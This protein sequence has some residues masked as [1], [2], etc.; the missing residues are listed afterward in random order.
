MGGNSREELTRYPPPS[1]AVLGF[2]NVRSQK[3][4]QIEKK[5][6]ELRLTKTFVTGPDKH[7][8]LGESLGK[9][10]E[11]WKIVGKLVKLKM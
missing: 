9:Q 10:L 3:K 11:R 8:K 4:T 1:P 6:N 5:K 2:V 7:C